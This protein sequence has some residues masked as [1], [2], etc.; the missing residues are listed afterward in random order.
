MLIIVYRQLV[1]ARQASPAG[2][3]DCRH[4]F[5][6]HCDIDGRSAGRTLCRLRS[7]GHPRRQSVGPYTRWPAY[8]RQIIRSGTS[9]APNYAEGRS[10]ESRADFIHKLRIA[11]KEMNET[12]IWLRIIMKS[13][14][15]PR[16]DLF[17]T[18]EE[19]DALRRILG[20]SLRTAR[21]R[22]SGNGGRADASKQ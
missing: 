19:C 1:I 4:G 7:R 13:G 2:K 11:I 5:K 12:A 10:A 9:A 18:A 6:R 15:L 22:A 21:L 20:A 8:R 17:A 16:E 3:S 14:V